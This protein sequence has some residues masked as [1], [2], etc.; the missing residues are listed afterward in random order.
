[1]AERIDANLLDTPLDQIEKLSKNV[2][3][4]KVNTIAARIIF[5]FAIGFAVICSARDTAGY[6]RVR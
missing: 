5:H 6:Q 1:I 2:F 4:N 3:V